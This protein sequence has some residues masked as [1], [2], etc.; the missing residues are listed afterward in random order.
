MSTSENSFPKDISHHTINKLLKS[1]TLP[2]A[3]NIV[4]KIDT[5]FHAIYMITLPP[6]QKSTCGCE[7]FYHNELVLCVSADYWPSIKIEN[8]LGVMN[9]ISN[10]IT[11]VSV[12]TLHLCE[13]TRNNPLGYEYTLLARV[14][15]D[16][17]SDIWQGLDDQ[18]R[19]GILDQLGDILAELH[20]H[21][22]YG[23]GGIDEEF[24]MSSDGD[25]DRLDNLSQVIDE[26]FWTISQTALWPADETI[27]SLNTSGPFKTYTDY[28]SAQISLYIRQI[29]LHDNLEFYRLQSYRL[30]AFLTV[31]EE[32]AEE[33]NKTRFI[34]AHKD[35]HF[36]NIMYD[37]KSGK[38][39]SILDWGFAGVVP[40][41]KWNP[42]KAFLWDCDS[43]EKGKA[44]RDLLMQRFMQRCEA[45]GVKPLP[46]EVEYTSPRQKAMQEIADHVRAIIEVK[47]KNQ[48]SETTKMQLQLDERVKEWEDTVSKALE[49]FGISSSVSI[50]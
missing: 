40:A 42:R 28:I 23:I 49:V 32:H 16:T 38:I 47:V 15:G 25:R 14:P 8:E 2:E 17:L 34:L 22:W 43:S 39:T 20:S 35:L 10:C 13:N 37:R 11:K 24:W 1:I 21:K 9:Y 4:H 30:E 33:L 26:T 29:R 41:P 31:L 45:R 46:D 12:P 7:P 48:Y 36:G 6:G 44:A 5:N 3:T 27:Q 50:K 18:Q 19:D